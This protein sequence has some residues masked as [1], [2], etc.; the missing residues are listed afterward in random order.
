MKK[1]MSRLVALV[2]AL[3]LVLSASAMATERASD[4]FRVPG[5]KQRPEQTEAPVQDEQAPAEEQAPADEQTPAE[6]QA[7]AE[8]QPQPE[9]Q[10][11]V[12]ED[13]KQ[14]DLQDGELNLRAGASSDAEIIGK[15]RSGELVTVLVTEGEWTK[16]RLANGTEGYVASRYLAELKLAESK[17]VEPEQPEAP[18][19]PVQPEAPAGPEASAE[20]EQPEAPAEPEATEEPEQPEAPAEPEVAD[21]K[22]PDPEPEQQEAPEASAEVEQPTVVAPDDVDVR[23]DA[24][25]MSEIIETIPEGVE[26]KV[27]EIIGDWVKV[28]IDGKIGY[29]YIDDLPE[30]LPPQPEEQ[31]EVDPENLPPVEVTIFSSRRSVMAPGEVVLLSSKIK[32]LEYYSEYMLQWQ[33]D[34]GAGFEDV[35]GATG[36]EHTFEASVETLGYDWKLLVYYR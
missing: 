28:E 5:A 19:E 21:S 32:N 29:I 33:V 1:S 24:D 8:A 12:S 35:P 11:Q 9:A 2:L 20:P 26:I 14:V 31:P 17:P 15:L 36:D 6:E 7:P 25:G 27:L 30:L 3:M 23:L 18:A 34:K 16:V 10:P 13:K 22:D 4:P